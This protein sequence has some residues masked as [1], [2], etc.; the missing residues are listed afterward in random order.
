MGAALAAVAGMMF[1]MYYGLIDFFIGFLAGIKAFTAAVLGGIGSLPGAM[2]GGLLI[3]LIEV[4]WAALLLERVQ[5]RRGLRHPRAGADLPAD[6]PAGQTGDREGLRRWSRACPTD[7]SEG[8]GPDRAGRGRA[9]HLHR[10]LPHLRCRLTH[11]AQLRL[12]LRR[13]RHRDRHIFFGR[14]GLSLPPWAWPGR[15]SRSARDGRSRCLAAEAA[16]DFPALVRGAGGLLIILR[17]I[18]P[19]ADRAGS[20]AAARIAARRVIGRTPPLARAR[21][22]WSPPS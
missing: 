20:H 7:A 4:F 9:R 2:L 5:G 13:S 17:T 19:W 21:R 14:L 1:L 10:R 18:W 11:R 22:C 15:R 3:G 6:R 12:S 16:V 8:R